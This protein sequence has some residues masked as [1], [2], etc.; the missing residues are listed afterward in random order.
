MKCSVGE[1]HNKKRQKTIENRKKTIK[2]FKPRKTDHKREE[3]L[4]KPQFRIF[5][6][7][8]KGILFGKYS[9]SAACFFCIILG[10]LKPKAAMVM[11]MN[12]KNQ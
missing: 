2:A 11:M 1:K 6:S 12:P 8:I 10:L 5:N 4:E 9:L 3:K 7:K